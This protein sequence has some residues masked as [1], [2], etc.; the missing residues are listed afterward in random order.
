MAKRVLILSLYLLTGWCSH[1]L[2]LSADLLPQMMGPLVISAPPD[3]TYNINMASCMAM[4]ELEPASI[5]TN[6]CMMPGVDFETITPFQM[7]V[8]N[9][10]TA[11]FPKGTHDVIYIATD[12]CG[13]EDRDTMQVTVVDTI[14]PSASCTGLRTVSLDGNGMAI[15]PAFVFNEGSTDFCPLFFKVKRAAAPTG[16]DCTTADNPNYMFDDEVKFCCEDLNDTVM[17]ILRVYDAMPPSGPVSDTTLRGSFSDCMTGVIVRDKAPPEL[18]CPPDFTIECGEHID[19]D[20]L[21]FPSFTDNCDSISYEVIIESDLDQCGVGELRRIIIGTDGGGQSDTCIQTIFVVNTEPFDAENPDDLIWPDPY[22]T[23]YDCIKVPD[24]SQ[25]GGPVIMDDECSMVSVSW[26]DEVYEFSRGACSKV[27]R[28]F[29]VLDWCQY[30]PRR[31]SVCAPA[32]GCW[33]FE[34]VIKVVDTIPPQIMRPNDTIVDYLRPGCTSMPVALDSATADTCF[35]GEEIVFNIQLDFFADGDIEHEINGPDASFDYPVGKHQVIYMA[36]DECN[37]TSTDT[38]ML[39]VKDRVL[40]TPTAKTGISIALTDMG[41]GMVMSSVWAK[42]LDA[43]SYDNCTDREDLVF[44]FSRDTSDRSRT[45]DCDSL[46]LRTVRMWVTDECGNQDFVTANVL[47]DDTGD[48]C[49]NNITMSSISGLVM[50]HDGM[51]LHDVDVELTGSTLKMMKRT[52]QE[53]EYMHDDLERHENYVVK[54][55]MADDPLKG[56]TTRDVVLIQRH[57]L[58]LSKFDQVYQYLGADANR[59]GHVSTS[60]IVSLRKLILGQQEEFRHGDEWLFIPD[61]WQFTDEHDP[62][63]TPWPA[64]YSLSNLQDPVDVNFRGYKI[65]DVDMSYQVN[66]NNGT[67]ESKEVVFDLRYDKE[68]NGL[69]L[70]N[71]EEK[72]ISG[73]QMFLQ[74][75]GFEGDDIVISTSL[76]NWSESNYRYDRTTNTLLISWHAMGEQ[77]FAADD[78]LQIRPKDITSSRSFSAILEPLA[79]SELY[80]S[81]AEIEDIRLASGLENSGELLTNIKVSPNPFRSDFVIELYSQRSLPV[82]IQMVDMLGRVVIERMAEVEQGWN[83]IDMSTDLTGN[84]VYVLRLSTSEIMREFRIIKSH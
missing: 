46:G 28:T 22:V 29:K 12:S 57:L 23:V 52:D 6:G 45:Y 82:N 61:G 16:Y 78:F 56:I 32:N 27:I 15:L 44:S 69:I 80:D 1:G 84:G 71:T 50:R 19:F 75:I 13:N 36:T 7:L 8:G 17:V 31:S 30:N 74:L 54:P 33:T 10:G 14:P 48:F 5:D 67:R 58:G 60:D 20:T 4:V 83:T 40:P 37:N 9:G 34:Q 25:S 77:W 55:D 59:S 49:P 62:W 76:D 35:F 79:T 26:K 39:E 38:M 42:D 18:T 2:A 11:T 43:S 66:G 3:T 73:C 51:K 72:W 63:A 53:G 81:E 68:L 47:V 24:T 65:G 64:N 21:D 70:T 41:N